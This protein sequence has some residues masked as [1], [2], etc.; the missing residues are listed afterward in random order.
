[1][2]QTNILELIEMPDDDRKFSIGSET[3]KELAK[4]ASFAEKKV[5]N[6][7]SPVD[8]N[9]SGIGFACRKGLKP[10][11]ANQDSWSVLKLGDYSI[12]GVFDGHGKMG[13]HVSNFVKESLPKLIVK[14]QRFKTTEMCEMLTDIYKRMQNMIA[15]ATR[16]NK[17]DALMSGC[18]TTVLI[19]DHLEKKLY[20]SWVG[21]SGAMVVKKPPPNQGDQKW[22][23]QKLTWDHKPDEKGE[24]SR[25][26]KT[27]GRVVF[28]G[29]ANHR[30]YAKQGRYPGLNMSRALGDLM[31]HRD[32]GISAEP[33]TCVYDLVDDDKMIVLCSDGV[34]EFISHPEVAAIVGAFPSAKAMA[35]AD[36]LAKESWERWIR[37][38]G[39]MVVD[40][41]TAVIIYLQ[42]PKA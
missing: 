40:D 24:R 16:L 33:T 12:Y 41:I 39:G 32:A 30:V 37:E 31:G 7:G 3:D 17:F 6:I 35:A 28:D 20:V 38:E 25:I 4:K 5:H 36:K 22:N 23:G 27:G 9:K 29:Y 34:W 21:D 14:D 11:T 15:T 18:T 19:H 2:D 13:H 10:E 26:E 42:E 8:P 1:M